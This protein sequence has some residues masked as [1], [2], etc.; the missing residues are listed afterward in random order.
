MESIINHLCI[1]PGD[2]RN[3]DARPI[4]LLDVDLDLVGAWTT[5][6][7]GTTTF[8]TLAQKEVRES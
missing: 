2:I 6:N 5:W 1:N 4:K 8:T 7:I 3:G